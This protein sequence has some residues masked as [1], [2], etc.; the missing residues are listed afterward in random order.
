MSK[1][2]PSTSNPPMTST[3]PLCP[4][5]SVCNVKS[6]IISQVLEHLGPDGYS[7]R[8][9]RIFFLL[10]SFF[11]VSPPG[12]SSAQPSRRCRSRHLGRIRGARK[13]GV[14]AIGI[15]RDAAS[16]VAEL[17][18]QTHPI[19]LLMAIDLLHLSLPRLGHVA[20]V[21]VRGFPHSAGRSRD[22]GAR[23]TRATE[24][25]QRIIAG[26]G[27][28]RSPRGHGRVG[29]VPC[30]DLPGSKIGRSRNRMTGSSQ[31]SRGRAGARGGRVIDFSYTR[32]C[33]ISLRLLTNEWNIAEVESPRERERKLCIPRDTVIT[34]IPR[35]NKWFVHIAITPAHRLMANINTSTLV[36]HTA[37]ILLTRRRHLGTCVMMV[38]ELRCSHRAHGRS[39]S[40]DPCRAHARA[41]SS[42]PRRTGTCQLSGLLRRLVPVL[43]LGLSSDPAAA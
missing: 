33:D 34:R 32:T 23:T 35:K 29:G 13:V 31:L 19:L 27:H 12:S 9:G 20:W 28:R 3:L 4:S 21:R 15:R 43:H 24:D 37:R 8:R 10:F 30:K 7:H 25:V 36:K 1:I 17:H 16:F 6:R 40:A 14:G 38:L 41:G 22:H 39:R 2:S 26:R 11:S 42:D 5:R 18:A